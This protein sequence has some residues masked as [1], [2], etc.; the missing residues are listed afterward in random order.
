MDYILPIP[1][2]IA[3]ALSILVGLAISL[4]MIWFGRKHGAFEDK[5]IISRKEFEAKMEE[6]FHGRPSLSPDEYYKAYFAKLGIPK[7]IPIRVRRIFEE[8]FEADF[9]RLKDDDDFSKELRFFWDYDSMIDV[10]IVVSLE[11]EFKVD[12][13]DEEAAQMKTIRSIIETIWNKT[14]CPIGS[15]GTDPIGQPRLPHHPACGSAPGGSEQPSPT[16]TG[17]CAVETANEGAS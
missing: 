1:A 15:P 7:D 3:I 10:E 16:A 11:K 6:A 17:Q 9:S 2:L 8:S 5:Y 12:I 13:S 4:P 14:K